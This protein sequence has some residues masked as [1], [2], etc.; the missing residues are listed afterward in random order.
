MQIPTRSRLRNAAVV[1]VIAL[2]SAALAAFVS[3][4]P[5]S[6]VHKKEK[7][8]PKEYFAESEY[9]VKASPR[10][11]NAATRLPRGGG[12]DQLGKPY[13]IAGKMYYPKEDRK[14]RKKGAASWYGDAFHGRLT[15]NG[16]I[17]DM[18]HLT[19]AHPTMPLPSYARV[20]N[21]ANGSSVIVRVNDRG[22]Y[23]HGR[24]IDLSKRAAEMLDYTHVGVAQVQ[25]E[26]V[27]RAP[28]DGQDDQYLMA[29]YKPGKDMPDPSDGLATGVMIAM[30][31][32]TPSAPI[33]A[34]TARCDSRRAFGAFPL[35]PVGP[36]APERPSEE[37]VPQTQVAFASMSYAMD[38]STAADRAF[39]ALDGTSTAEQIQDSWKR[40][41]AGEGGEYIAVGSFRD[42]AEATRIALELSGSGRAVL[43][44]SEIDGTIW[45][46][47]ALE[48][49]GRQTLDQMLQ[50]A[51]SL[52]ASDAM[53]VRN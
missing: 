14:Y 23:A 38:S 34:R 51:W 26:Y 16:E 28:L 35:A 24:I 3:S 45:H 43:A 29:S 22:P 12:R 53:P 4:P 31:G 27:G 48:A 5:K 17:Y 42:A 18:T 20:T 32:P 46:S 50:A 25:V 13:A 2:S 30:N 36:V 39:A 10:V 52:G 41:P 8:R 37:I 49:D 11:T 33:G 15:A 1:S 7:Q 6:M 9:G 47:V 40:S 21:V 19:A 44:H